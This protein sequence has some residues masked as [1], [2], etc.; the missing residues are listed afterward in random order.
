MLTIYLI[1]HNLK[2]FF[3]V[4]LPSF[5]FQNL[6]FASEC[7][8]KPAPMIPQAAGGMLSNPYINQLFNSQIYQQQQPLITSELHHKPL[9]QIMYILIQIGYNF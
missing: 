4:Y 5:L 8:L 7:E 9:N 6:P 2:T 3:I 1:I